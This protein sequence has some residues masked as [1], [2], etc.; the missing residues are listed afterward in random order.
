MRQK[1]KRFQVLKNNLEKQVAD[2][3][4]DGRGGEEKN[5]LCFIK[6]MSIGANHNL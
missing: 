3:L 6:F 5:I 1:M 2:S 4:G